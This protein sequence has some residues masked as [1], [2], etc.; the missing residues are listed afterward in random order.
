[1]NNGTDTYQTCRFRL[2]LAEA[3][4]APQQWAR[5]TQYARLDSRELSRLEVTVIA[6]L[7]LPATLSSSDLSSSSASHYHHSPTV[8]FEQAFQNKAE[9]RL[10]LSYFIRLP[11]KE[12]TDEQTDDLAQKLGW[13][14]WQACNV[15]FCDYLWQRTCLECFIGGPTSEYIEINVS[16]AGQYALY[17]FLD[18]RQPALMPPPPLYDSRPEKEIGGKPRAKIDWHYTSV[19]GIKE[20]DATF[21]PQHLARISSEPKSSFIEKPNTPSPMLQRQFS[22]A[23]NQLPKSLLAPTQLHPCVIIYLDDIPLYF[24]PQH[25]AEPDFHDRHYWQNIAAV[26]GL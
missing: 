21:G 14:P 16:P 15:G 2:T 7:P 23:L 4:I 20:Y 18:Y 6:Y 1:M 13:E 5:L 24:A 10:W 3:S 17:H 25:A 12:S 26:E 8:N 19:N 9:P 11:K 22:I